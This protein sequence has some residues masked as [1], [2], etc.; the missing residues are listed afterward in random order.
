[1]SFSQATPLT[2]VEHTGFPPPA[3]RRRVPRVITFQR[4]RANRRIINEDGLLHLLSQYGHIRVVEFNSS[5]SFADQLGTMRDT[6]VFVSAHTSNLANAVFLQPGSA[7][8][9]IIQVW[10]EHSR[11]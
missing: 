3:R 4:K 11:H 10:L 1:M 2:H 5:T 7:V 6:G 8:I 9:E